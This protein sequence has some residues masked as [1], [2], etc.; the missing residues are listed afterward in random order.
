MSTE[1]EIVVCHILNSLLPS[2]A[3]TMLV[4]SSKRM[5]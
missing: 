5:E 1:K 4:N 2:G 3:E